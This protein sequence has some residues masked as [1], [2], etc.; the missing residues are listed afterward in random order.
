MEKNRKWISRLC[1]MVAGLGLLATLV[2]VPRQGVHTAEADLIW[3]GKLRNGVEQVSLAE[4]DGFYLVQRGERQ[5]LLL[6][7]Y[8][9]AYEAPAWQLDKGKLTL[10]VQSRLGEHTDVQLYR[11]QLKGYDTLLVEENGQNAVFQRIIVL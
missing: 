11:I 7:G 10:S 6:R 5:Y 8:G 2:F 4:Q 1:L 3:D 9:K